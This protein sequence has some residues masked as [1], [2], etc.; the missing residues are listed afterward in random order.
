MD[1]VPSLLDGAAVTIQVTAGAVVVAFVLAMLAGTARTSHRRPLAWL[2]TVYVEVFRGTSALAQ[3]YFIFFALPL[4]GVYLS[5]MTAGVLAL[6]LNGGAYGAEIVRGALNAV[7]VGQTEAAVALSLGP[8]TQ[9]RRVIAPL[10]VPIMLPSACNLVVDMLKNS[11]LVSLITLADITAEAQQ[12]RFASGN[13]TLLFGAAMVLYFLLSTVVV[14]VFRVMERFADPAG[15]RG[16]R[17][18]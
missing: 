14:L 13:T 12:L 10:A 16:G 2:A 9:Y 8:W 1:I 11:A 3:L 6:G 7:P 17:G 15:S 4:L 5:P 18:R